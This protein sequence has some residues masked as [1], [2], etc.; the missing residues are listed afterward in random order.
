M[1]AFCVNLSD[2]F[3]MSLNIKCML[4]NNWAQLFDFARHCA[5]GVKNVTQSPWHSDNRREPLLTTSTT[6][7]STT[8]I[9]RDFTGAKRNSRS[10]DDLY[11]S[12]RIK[13]S[14]VLKQKKWLRFSNRLST[15][16]NHWQNFAFS[17]NKPIKIVK[18]FIRWQFPLNSSKNILFFYKI[19]ILE[20]A[21]YRLSS[22][23]VDMVLYKP[24]IFLD[25]QRLQRQPDVADSFLC[26][27]TYALD[28][29]QR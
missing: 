16:R 20:I 10:A 8:S 11:K 5:P 17:V 9:I 22:K 19:T 25:H 29:H 18:T 4:L 26:I 27:V 23:D 21:H 14:K 28:E 1:W 2:K 13:D 12:Q 6:K 24:T 15:G 3:W 7:L